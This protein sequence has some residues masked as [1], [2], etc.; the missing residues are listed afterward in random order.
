MVTIAGRKKQ[1][2][3]RD[4]LVFAC[5]HGGVGGGRDRHAFATVSGPVLIWTEGL[6]RDPQNQRAEVVQ[7]GGALG[8]NTRHSGIDYTTS[9]WSFRR[10]DRAC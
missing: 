2:G 6:V 3:C 8:S 5:R 10:G 1:G 9:Q 4:R 7:I